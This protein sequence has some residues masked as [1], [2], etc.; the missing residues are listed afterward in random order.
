MS[1]NGHDTDGPSVAIARF[2]LEPLHF[3]VD[4]GVVVDIDNVGDQTPTDAL[5]LSDI[6]GIPFPEESVRQ[7]LLR[8]EIKGRTTDLIVG[9][10]V[11]TYRVPIEC[12]RNVPTFL[13]GVARLAAI[14]GFLIEDNELTYLLDVEEMLDRANSTSELGS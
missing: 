2:S 6:V 3:A 4:A 9:P 13:V 12:F 10:E 11:D 8:L 14:S 7:R 5:L 1:D